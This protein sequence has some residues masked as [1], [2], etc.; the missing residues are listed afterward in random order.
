[1]ISPE[2]YA[3]IALSGTTI[4]RIYDHSQV[5]FGDYYRV[6][7]EAR[8]EIPLSLHPEHSGDAG[9]VA[10]YSRSLEKMAVP[11]AEVDAV[12]MSLLAEFR[13][14]S[15]PYLAAPDF[16]AKFVAKAFGRRT[17]VKKHYSVSHG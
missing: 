8:C 3:E 5:Y 11:S 12:R 17:G 6:R 4:I 10:V 1:M 16:P 14:N 15:L 2:L 7:L 9:E 13:Q